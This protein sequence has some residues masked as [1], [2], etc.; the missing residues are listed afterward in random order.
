MARRRLKQTKAAR[1]SRAR[2]RRAKANGTVRK[3]ARGR[4]KKRKRGGFMGPLLASVGIP[5]I[6]ELIG[7]LVRKN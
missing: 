5:L 4:G 2:Y 1:A 7:K 6:G 3:R